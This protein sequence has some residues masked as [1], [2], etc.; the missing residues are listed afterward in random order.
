VNELLDWLLI[1]VQSV[2]PLTRNLLAGLAIML[3][4]SLFVGL[5][6]PGDTVVLVASTGV[7]DIADFFVLIGC[8]LLGSLIGESFGFWIGRLFGQRI[9]NSKLGQ[10]IGEKNWKLADSFIESRGGLAVAISRFLPVLHSLVP[11]VAGASTMRYRVFIRWTLAA[12]AIWASVYVGVGYLAHTSYDKIGT[13]LK[14]GGLIFVAII[15]I[16]LIIVHFAK[17]RLEKT[18]L[19]MVADDKLKQ[20]EKLED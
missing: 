15:L 10:R 12:C 17:K 20:F 3:E 9:R 16:F 19:Q 2:D 4:T 7:I 13:N 11:V 6:M 14:F 1:T 5:I 8:V 18:A